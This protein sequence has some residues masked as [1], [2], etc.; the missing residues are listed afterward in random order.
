MARLRRASTKAGVPASACSNQRMAS[1]ARL[2][3][4]SSTPIPLAASADRGSLSRP[5]R[6]ASSAAREVA[7]VAARVAQVG[8]ERGVGGIVLHRPLERRHR[9]GLAS[10]LDQHQA[11][12]VRRGGVGRLQGERRLLGARGFGRHAGGRRR[13]REV[14]IRGP[15]H[16]ASA[17]RGGGR[18]P[19]PATRGPCPSAPARRWPGRPGR[20]DRRAPVSSAR[21]ARRAHPRPTAASTRARTCSTRRS[22][23]RDSGAASSGGAAAPET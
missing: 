8:P 19:L 18:S 10:L 13:H 4:T 21:R 1:G 3:W 23:S 16:R 15:R 11:E 7:R 2:A 14:V 12:A 17:R 9:L 6:Y 5:R 20:R 22:V